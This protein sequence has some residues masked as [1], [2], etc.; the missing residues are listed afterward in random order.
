MTKM[1]SESMTTG[2]EVAVIG[3]DARFPGA[4]NVGEF[5]ENLKNSRE[6]ICFFSDC[7]LS[8]S[9]IE[10]GPGQHSNYVKAM[11]VLADI[12]FFDAAFFGYTP[13]EAEI[14][15]PQVRVLHECAWRALE[16]AGYVPD[17]FPGSIGCYAGAG[18]GLYWAALAY[19]SGK[20]DH[21]GDFSSK[22]L[23]DKD[24][25]CTHLAYKLNLKGPAL[26]MQTACSTSLV[27]IH[28]ACQGLIAGECDMALAGG[29]SVSYLKK[30]GYFYQ[31]GMILS[32][33][34]HCRAF[35]TRAEGTNFGDGVGVVV[36][37]S[38]EDAVSDRDHIY[39]VIKGSFIN[40][41]GV[42]KANFTAPSI[43]GQAAV[44]RTAHQ[45]A[46]IEPDTIT[47]I[48]TH[49]TGTSLGDPVEIEGLKLAFD[50]DKTHFCALG[51]VKSN[52]GHLN[53]A[54][55]M[56]GLIKAILALK[57]HQIPPSLH[58]E[59][60]N[61][62]IK[63]ENSPFF[64]NTRL[65]EW[66]S[67]EYPL[68]AGISS[69]GIGGTNAHVILEEWN[70][71]P[72]P[73]TRRPVPLLSLPDAPTL[74]EY[75]LILLSARTPS[76]LVKMHENLA[77]Y[78]KKILLNQCNHENPV[79][80]GI[81]L[82]DA[83]YTLQLG[84]KAFEYRQF[85]VCSHIDEAITALSSPSL[86]GEKTAREEEE[87]PA[88]I[89]M[90][91]GLGTQYVNMGLE[92]YQKE[93]LF[94][95]D[96]DRCFDLLESLTGYDIKKILY[97]GESPDMPGKENS[98]PV[99]GS[100]GNRAVNTPGAVHEK[101]QH[102][103]IAQPVI[104][105]F[106]YALARLLM[107]WGIKPDAMI[108]YSFGEYIAAC[109]SGVLSLEHALKLIVCRGELLKKVPEGAMLSV[110]L[111][112]NEL[113]PFLEDNNR[114]SLAIDNGD[115][116]IIAGPVDVVDI[117]E[118][119][120]RKN[121]QMCMR[122]ETSRAIHSKMMSPILKQLEGEAGDIDL[123]EPRIPYISNVTGTWTTAEDVLA[124]AYWSRHLRDTVQF[125]DGIKELVKKENTIFLEIGPGRELTA[126][127]GRYIN[128]KSG[129]KAINLLPNREHE[130]PG[131]YY[132][133]NKIG[134]L[135][136]NGVPP[137]WAEFQEGKA[138]QRI[139]LPVYP[140]EKQRYWLEGNPFKM[141][142]S[143][144][145]ENNK[146]GEN[147]KRHMKQ[148]PDTDGLIYLP[149]WKR[150]LL[151]PAKKRKSHH[152]Y[153]WLIFINELN[154]EQLIVKRLEQKE[155]RMVIVKMGENFKKEETGNKGHTAIYSINPENPDH[156]DAL[157]QQIKRQDFLPHKIVQSWNVT[158]EYNKI[159]NRKTFDKLQFF[160]F[161]S[162][163]YMVKAIEK[164]GIVHDIDITILSDQ[165]QEVTGTE[166][167]CP[168]KATVLGL[169]KSI[170]QEYPGISCCSIDIILPEPGMPGETV[171]SD[172]LIEEFIS[173]PADFEVA[174]REN[175]RWVQIF[176]PL[177]LENIE[178]EKEP[179]AFK[180]RTGG[181][182]LVTGGMGTIGLIFAELLVKRVGARLIL[183]GRSPF[184]PMQEWNN[185]LDEHDE[186]DP[187]SLK[188]KKLHQLQEI[189][190]NVLYFQVDAADPEEMRQVISRSEEI[191]GPINGVIHAAGITS[192][193]SFRSVHQL[194]YDNCQ[195]QFHPKVYGTLVLEELFKESALDF[196]WMLSSI[197]CVLGGLGFGAY[198]SAN[199]FMDVFVKRFNRSNHPGAPWFSLNWDG[200]DAETSSILF[201]QLFTVDNVDQLV[202][203]SEGHLQNRINRWI[204]LE[205]LRD[206]PQM[207]KQS[208]VVIDLKPR[209]D[210]M[211]P[212]VEPG[213]PL[214][215][216][217]A[218]IWQHSFGFEK[219]GI[220]DDFF[221]LGG[222]SLKAI[223]I[224]R[225][226]HQQLN[227]YVPLKEFFDRPT[228]EKLAEYIV[229]DH[230]VKKDIFYFHFIEP[231]E[232]KDYYVLSPAQKRLFV[233]Q[234]M[235]PN[236]ISYNIST[237]VMLQGKLNK[238]Q[239]ENAIKQ[240][241]RRHESLRTRFIMVHGEAIQEIEDKVDFSIDY[242]QMENI[243]QIAGE[244][245]AESVEM[246]SGTE[247]TR[248]SPVFLNS[249]LSGF[250]SQFMHPFDLSQPPMM[251]IGLIELEDQ[252][253][254]LMAD[255]HHIA[256]DGVSMAILRRELILLYCENKLPNLKIQYKD[257]SQWKNLEKDTPILKKMES[258]WLE[259]FA[260]EIP[261]LNLPAD[262]NRP[263]TR[264][265]EGNS[266]DFRVD[267][268]ETKA[269]EEMALKE[270]VT[271]YIVLLAICYVFLSRV[272]GDE[273]IVI[274]ASP[275][276]RTHMDLE[277]I[278]G[279]FANTVALRC[280]PSGNKTFKG[281][282][283]EVKKLTL[284]GFENQAY[285][286]DELIEALEIERDMSRT[287]L[288]D[289]MF[290]FN[291]IEDSDIEI[292]G[293]KVL[294]LGYKNK[295]A[296]FD[297][298]FNSM[299]IGGAIFLNLEYSTKLFKEST[300]K[301]FI[302]YFCHILA[303]ILD[304]PDIK[305]DEIE[306]ITM[307]KKQLMH[308]HWLSDLESE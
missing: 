150:S 77:E 272:S 201:Q 113:E 194:S 192:G 81:I 240:L 35:D 10:P 45:I 176:D 109:I 213:S 101:I 133:M 170:H 271:L 71:H 178:F 191:F 223:N 300:I 21:L 269:L 189:G 268:R 242:F 28:I 211:T 11:G 196:C 40:N 147:N 128:G 114:L 74:P 302:D 33:D 264:S 184:P 121:R 162:L 149:S 284:E 282:L 117:F 225:K 200:M 234:Q 294:P 166:P 232:K 92:L 290:M 245:A 62:K 236:A 46:E 75:Q 293:L 263:D 237:A 258:Y 285:Q 56:A 303:S 307:A 231:V 185:W 154:F 42:R 218:R 126:L 157:F 23:F 67:E 65:L 210:L 167:L 12:E 155:Q 172:S 52:V 222:D 224:E 186:K 235:D 195:S 50:T 97:P 87:K 187:V 203:S 279:M 39:A 249:N 193:E 230:E 98:P 49:G 190:G 283:K 130:I 48:E 221:D 112:K 63:L 229:R 267:Y 37:K 256:A 298:N 255:I 156:Y 289:V 197:S 238:T 102:L 148:E 116:C 181:V 129:Q 13:I 160:G 214:E 34:G 8:G 68:R 304:N 161:Y 110:P 276:G 251:R 215:K 273:D 26:V 24:F 22:L 122:V 259:Q 84:R 208:P 120:M 32:P 257:F 82:A 297:L 17:S 135:W 127:V 295:M 280:Y 291:N 204:K 180:L 248:Y 253:H 64:V 198:A 270:G 83:A 132:F 27:A 103:D 78:F 165:L 227:V 70:E 6:S 72:S 266:L 301:V 145:R 209:P 173:R 93:T 182:Y 61:P 175:Q 88:V 131:G 226:L 25:L 44:I 254:I 207:N 281:F 306:M 308:Q 7:E 183:T 241:I 169:L 43:E 296:K 9:G 2:L 19:I 89:F 3:M 278:I 119:E 265:F 38:L 134:Q 216:D 111:P 16:D 164:Q 107:K 85:F 90:F 124:P 277:H 188:I 217:I 86:P 20:K 292:P 206:E 91:P 262:Y 80:P 250:I 100:S 144:S 31:K 29:V 159:I 96:M 41:D 59:T 243:P 30:T 140:F 275:E 177:P 220:K 55:G 104:F 53:A 305:L 171:L 57:H 239:L 146:S 47:Y 174:Y 244:E 51:S 79:E 36:L 54:A 76:A 108:G 105:I 153:K 152:Q 142:A 261:V 95:R 233:L 199:V 106:A 168:E 94:R 69:F 260:G 246:E 14:M 212:Y 115:S 15:D 205:A 60:L 179:R 5:W 139:P 252:K 4:E 137:D 138:R 58:F 123:E 228:I 125:A 18:L 73:D 158:G 219:I 118:K 143:L 136:L 202:I 274:G 247:N 1:E 163:L 299:K 287:P 288:F 99:P 151:I 66:K 286:F 141:G